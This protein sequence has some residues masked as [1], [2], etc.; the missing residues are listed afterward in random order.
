MDMLGRPRSAHLCLRCTPHHPPSKTTNIHL[1][2]FFFRSFSLTHQTLDP[3]QHLFQAGCSDPDRHADRPEAGHLL[4]PQGQD[5]NTQDAH[6]IRRLPGNLT[7]LAYTTCL[8]HI[9]AR[10]A[11]PCA[12]PPASVHVWCTCCCA[13]QC[14]QMPARRRYGM[15]WWLMANWPL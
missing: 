3:T 10:M 13:C 11:R 14:W 7:C 1:H 2:T 12:T 9:R 15:C 4:H 5:Q 8:A 6:G